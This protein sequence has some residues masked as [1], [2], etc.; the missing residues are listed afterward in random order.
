MNEMPNA[1]L[2][3]NRHTGDI[4]GIKLFGST[5]STPKFKDDIDPATIEFLDYQYKA[6]SDILSMSKNFYIDVE[7]GE[8]V[9]RCYTEEQLVVLTNDSVETRVDDI[10]T[11]IA[12]NETVVTL[13]EDAIINY[14][15]ETMAAE[16]NN[17]EN[18][19]EEPVVE[20]TTN[21]TV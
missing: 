8:V 11:L 10:R 3:Y 12:G 2:Y 1:R 5:I 16:E 14:Q 9:S 18:T 13:V 7:T 20:P 4:V 15:L 17:T 21:T 6:L 19:T